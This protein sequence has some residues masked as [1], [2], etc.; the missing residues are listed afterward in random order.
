MTRILVTGA[1]GFAAFLLIFRKGIA[2]RSD[3]AELGPTYVPIDSDG[4]DG[5][6]D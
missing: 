1:A 6:G 4:A 2:G 3:D 5:G